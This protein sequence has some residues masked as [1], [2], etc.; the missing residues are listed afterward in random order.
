MLNDAKSLETRHGRR[1][2]RRRG[3]RVTVALGL[4]ALMGGYAPLT[5]A[6][7]P[8]DQIRSLNAKC[9]NGKL[10]VT[11]KSSLPEGTELEI[12]LL[13]VESQTIKVNG[14]GKGVA[15]WTGRREPGYVV[16]I[17]GCDEWCK[18][19]PCE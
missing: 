2:A 12:E 18:F 19:V 17:K 14:R 13:H 10:K 11:V 3:C 7:P 4:L 1:N 15:K 16:C 6:D 9:K 5:L 8:C